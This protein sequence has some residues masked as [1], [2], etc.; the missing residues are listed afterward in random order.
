MGIIEDITRFLFVEDPPEKA[1]VIMVVGSSCPELAERA[2]ELWKAGFAPFVLIGGGVSVK[3]GR[4]PGPQSKGDVYNGTYATEYDFYF[5]VLV[6]N[7]VHAN[8]VFGENRSGY[9]RQNAEFAKLAAEAMHRTVDRAILVCKSFHARRSLMF[10]Q[11]AFP[12]TV[13]TVVP[14][15][16]YDISKNN[17]YLSEYGVSRVLGEIKRCGDQ[18]DKNDIDR[19]LHRQP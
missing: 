4:F 2:A 7:G 17:W 15:N 6:K 8:A 18:L 13:L 10:Y 5:D 19:F 14:V 1:D 11:S 3:T 12:D 16:C 9:T